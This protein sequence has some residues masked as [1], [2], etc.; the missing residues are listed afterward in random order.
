MINNVLIGTAE[1]LDIVMPTCYL[2]EYNKNYRNS[3]GS[4]LNYYRD[5]PN[6]PPAD[7]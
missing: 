6:N 4:L 2:I 5:K 1:D 7:N 3:T